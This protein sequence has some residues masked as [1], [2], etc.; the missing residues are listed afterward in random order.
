[1]N[2]ILNYCELRIDTYDM[3]EVSDSVIAS[4]I[5]GVDKDDAILK[6]LF[7]CC[8]QFNSDKL[9]NS[10]DYYTNLINKIAKISGFDYSE[11][12]LKIYS[13]FAIPTEFQNAREKEKL[14]RLIEMYEEVNS[15]TVS[16][17]NLMYA[18]ES[19]RYNLLL[20]YSDN[21]NKY[22]DKMKK[23][24]EELKK[25]SDNYIKLRDSAVKKLQ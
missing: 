13:A 9:S 21:I 6:V 23:L 8:H 24:L 17:D 4:I 5:E 1:M 25:N 3:S 12:E 11:D 7:R 14:E 10:F 2:N 18:Q 19:V 15:M 22:Y 20:A 16:G